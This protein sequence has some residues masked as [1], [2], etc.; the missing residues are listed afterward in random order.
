MREELSYSFGEPP[1]EST[2]VQDGEKWWS[3]SPGSGAYMN[4]GDSNSH[5]GT[6]MGLSMFG[7]SEFLSFREL[8]IIGLTTQAGRAAIRVLSL[9][10]PRDSYFYPQAHTLYREIPQELLIDAERGVIL[11]SVSLLDD[12]PFAIR[13]F[14]S[15]VF[16]EEIPDETFVFV[17]PPGVEVRDVRDVQGDLQFVQL[18]EA[19]RDAPFGNYV[20][21]SV[22]EGWRMRVLFMA[23]RKRHGPTTVG[24]HYADAMARV[25]VNI[26]EQ[27]ADD[28][29]MPQQ[30]PNGDDWRIEQLRSGELRLWEPSEPER[31]MP[32]IGLLELGGTRIQISSGDLDLEAIAQLAKDLVAA[33]AEPPVSS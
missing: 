1:Y 30:A 33:P 25:N 24:I 19:V 29:G 7:A 13:E 27:A 14:L 6:Q 16:D 17:P 21:S 12:E 15:V 18:H 10:S 28:E 5:H 8:E 9:S 20:P 11:R 32:C 2:V 23:Q 4:D 26:K 31:G 3:Y 22:P